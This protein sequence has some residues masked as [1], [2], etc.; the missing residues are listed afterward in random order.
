MDDIKDKIRAL[1]QSETYFGIIAEIAQREN[2]HLKTAWAMV[3]VQRKE[4]GLR[5]RFRTY[6]SYCNAKSN[7][8]KRG[9]MIRILSPPDNEETNNF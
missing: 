1:E 5:P 8:H 4:L 6:N 3:E 9:E 7:H 2:V